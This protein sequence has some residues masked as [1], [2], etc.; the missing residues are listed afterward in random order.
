MV[1]V[2]DF[3]VLR[4]VI[5]SIWQSSFSNTFTSTWVSSSHKSRNFSLSCPN[6][7][8]SNTNQKPGYP[9]MVA[10][11]CG[12]LQVYQLQLPAQLH[13]HFFLRSFSFSALSVF[14]E[15]PGNLVIEHDTSN[16]VNHFQ[17][18]KLSAWALVY[19]ISDL[20]D[21][22]QENSYQGSF[23]LVPWS[24]VS[25][26]SQIRFVWLQH[27]SLYLFHDS[28]NKCLSRY[29]WPFLLYYILSH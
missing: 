24:F 26:S 21:D 14:V 7:Y 13:F 2:F 1:S 28:S 20:V 16:Y 17:G 6:W 23:F 29:I 18:V 10:D 5:I 25:W 12:R 3:F 27:I 9:G 19:I 15:Y 22:Y 4:G 11:Y 8:H